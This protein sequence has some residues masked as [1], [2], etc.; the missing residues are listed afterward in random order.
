[1]TENKVKEITTEERVDIKGQ[2]MPG[3]FIVNTQ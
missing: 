1:M 3:P 2:F